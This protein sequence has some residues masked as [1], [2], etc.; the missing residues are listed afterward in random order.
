MALLVWKP[1]LIMKGKTSA[2]V[3]YPKGLRGIVHSKKYQSV[4]KGG[5]DHEYGGACPS[6]KWSLWPVSFGVEKGHEECQLTRHL[7]RWYTI[8]PWPFRRWSFFIWGIYKN[9]NKSWNE[10]SSKNILV[11]SVK[12]WCESNKA[13]LMLKWD[14]QFGGDYTAYHN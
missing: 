10:S 13:F 7:G 6:V 9:K 8:V 11:F 5:L 1:T 14:L 4:P 12:E 3:A 2:A